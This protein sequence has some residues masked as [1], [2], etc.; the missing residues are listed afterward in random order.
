MNRYSL[1]GA[2]G[3][4]G[5]AAKCNDGSAAA[6]YYR[7][8][9]A[10]WDRKA[11]APDFCEKGTAEGVR[12]VV[13]EI[14]FAQTD[15]AAAADATGNAGWC[16]S[17]AECAARKVSAANLTSSAGLPATLFPSGL[18][19]G[20]AEQNPNLYKAV[21]VIVPYCSSDLWLGDA[22]EFRGCASLAF[23]LASHAS[24]PSDWLRFGPRR[25]RVA[26]RARHLSQTA[27]PPRGAR[28]PDGHQGSCGG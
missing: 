22:G 11:G 23:W 25:H 10:N 9:S 19:S 1:A 14:V 17:A 2:G 20:F 26:S 4:D 6:Y 12:E 7:N 8:C 28:R 15:V 24:V 3:D 27:H 18:L 5:A 13:W 16:S 21:S